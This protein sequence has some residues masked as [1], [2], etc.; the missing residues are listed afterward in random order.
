MLKDVDMENKLNN[1]T[2]EE[3]KSELRRLKDNL[4]DIEDMHSFTFSKTSAHIGSEKAQNMQIEF[5]EE[6]S[7]LNERIAEIEKELK[8]K[9]EEI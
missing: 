5:E 3:L 7:M 2:V 9:A 8:K 1:M 6:C 4:C